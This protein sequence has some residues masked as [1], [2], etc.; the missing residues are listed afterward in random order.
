MWKLLKYTYNAEFDSVFIV[1]SIVI[2]NFIF[3]F[4]VLKI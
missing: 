1:V 4:P 2:L 3:Y